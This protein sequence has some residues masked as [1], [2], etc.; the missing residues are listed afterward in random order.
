MHSHFQM[1]ILL[2]AKSPLFQTVWHRAFLVLDSNLLL[3]AGLALPSDPPAGE[4][5][6][7]A[8][9][10]TRVA[11]LVLDRAAAVF[12]SQAAAL[13]DFSE[14][15]STTASGWIDRARQAAASSPQLAS[16]RAVAA[17]AAVA[18]ARSA[19]TWFP[20]TLA[21]AFLALCA[22][23]ARQWPGLGAT[24]GQARDGGDAVSDVGAGEAEPTAGA[25]PRSPSARSGL[26]PPP[27]PPR[28]P[29]ASPFPAAASASAAAGPQRGT[30]AQRGSVSEPT[31]ALPLSLSPASAATAVGE[32]G[33]WALSLVGLRR[34]TLGPLLP[35]RDLTQDSMAP[36]DP[37]EDPALYPSRDPSRD[38][39]REP[40]PGTDPEGVLWVRGAGDG[41]PSSSAQTG[42][43]VRGSAEGAGLDSQGGGGAP[44]PLW[45]REEETDTEG[46]AEGSGEGSGGVLWVRE[47][48]AVSG[49]G[50]GSAAAVRGNGFAASAG[51]AEKAVSGA[52]GGPEGGLASGSV[53]GSGLGSGLGADDAAQRASQ[54]LLPG[55]GARG[56][57]LGRNPRAGL[58]DNVEYADVGLHFGK[59]DKMASR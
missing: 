32:A 54:E 12:S 9:E 44:P 40:L 19:P 15:F 14:K 51:P 33:W 4:A 25:A 26:A 5:P 2:L 43:P 42:V 28:M 27:P 17:A 1:T 58:Y 46:S 20:P 31:P 11:D 56:M 38:P 52:V 39:S 18:A 23:W 13:G 59:K 10:P 48:P 34:T 53:L 16:A 37:S 50:K 24:G 49:G 3:G 57:S 6:A 47:E 30:G 36:S 41:Y 21:A 55:R 45:I 8:P 7:P 35:L 22:A 29:S